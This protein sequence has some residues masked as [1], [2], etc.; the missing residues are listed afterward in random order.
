MNTESYIPALK[1]DWLTKLYDPV[2]GALMPEK[3]FKSALIEQASLEP[4]SRVLDFGC[5]SLTLS[6]RLLKNVLTQIF[7]PLMWTRIY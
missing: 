7:M 5:G 1:F 4:G 3:Q 2:V 6:L